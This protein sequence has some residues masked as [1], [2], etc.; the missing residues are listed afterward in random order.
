MKGVCGLGVWAGS[1]VEDGAE[2]QL[3]NQQTSQ[4]PASNQPPTSD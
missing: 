4:Q 3:T 2:D 1:R